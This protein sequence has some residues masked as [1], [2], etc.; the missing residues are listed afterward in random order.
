MTIWP[1]KAYWYWFRERHDPWW[2]PIKG[3]NRQSSQ[4]SDRTPVVNS[5]RYLTNLIFFYHL[6]YFILFHIR[7]RQH[8][9]HSLLII[10]F[11]ECP[12]SLAPCHATAAFAT[13]NYQMFFNI[14]LHYDY[15]LL[16]TSLTS[17]LF[18]KWYS[19][20]S[21]IY[22]LTRNKLELFVHFIARENIFLEDL[23]KNMLQRFNLRQI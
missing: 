13:K 21:S 10:T 11:T 12:A 22:N 20:D 6:N 16:V 23:I 8:S 9:R 1:D 15:S 5:I 2:D 19:K 4:S 14:S 7:Q 18:V 17:A 3:R